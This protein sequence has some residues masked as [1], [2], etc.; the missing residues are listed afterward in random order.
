M[1]STATAAGVF[2]AMAAGCTAVQ[3]ETED[4]ALERTEA[5]IPFADQRTSIRDWQADGT[6]GIWVQDAHR[7]WYYG[8]FHLT[9]F[10]LDFATVVGFRTGGTAR[11]DRFS[12]IEVPQHGR[13][14]L[15]SFTTSEG[16][17]GED[18]QATE[19]TSGRD[20]P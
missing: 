2:A 6:R 18:R 16:P 11:L 13:C 8:S 20:P 12:S 7:N 5:S 3:P 9:C 17:P 19:E 4:V 15:R 1:R 10:G 14:T